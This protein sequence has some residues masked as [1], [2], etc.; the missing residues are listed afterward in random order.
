MQNTWSF[1]SCTHMLLYQLWLFSWC[2]IL[3]LSC[4]WKVYFYNV[5]IS[6]FSFNFYGKSIFVFIFYFTFNLIFLYLFFFINSCCQFIMKLNK[7]D[8][9]LCN[10]SYLAFICHFFSPLYFYK[11]QDAG[12]HNLW[13]QITWMT[14]Q[15]FVVLIPYYYCV[16]FIFK[17]G[18]MLY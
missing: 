1:L 10:F 4:H 14:T 13:N 16:V 12:L 6:H 18:Q 11:N 17:A 9:I 5:F 15:C 3:S 2:S 8:K 7:R